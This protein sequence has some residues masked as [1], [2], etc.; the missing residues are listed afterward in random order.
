M[1]TTTM[2]AA[3]KKVS[4]LWVG[5][6]GRR[7]SF[8]RI[9]EEVLGRLPIRRIGILAPPRDRITDPKP[10]PTKM[11]WHV[12]DP[13]SH[14]QWE[15]FRR[16]CGG[17]EITANMKYVVLQIA[18]IVATH[19]FDYVL[20]A[21]GICEANWFAGYQTAWATAKTVVWVPLDYLPSPEVVAPLAGTLF[22]TMSEE[23]LGWLPKGAMALGHGSS[24]VGS[25]FVGSQGREG[26]LG[27]LR[28]MGICVGSE[29]VV[30]L[31]ANNYV[32]RKQF[33]ITLEAMRRVPGYRLWIHSNLHE[34]GA[35]LE[36]YEDLGDR[37]ILTMNDKPSEFL[38]LP[39]TVC[40]VGLQT[41]S[42]EGWSLTNCEHAHMGGIQVVPDFLATGQHFR[43]LG[44]TY[45][46]G[47]RTETNEMGHKVVV[48]DI[49]VDDVVAALREALGAVGTEGHREYTKAARKYLDGH[50]WGNVTKRLMEII[51]EK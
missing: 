30:V 36:E 24:F 50:S 1:A 27:V 33:R 8:S 31:N 12:G 32:P 13:M 25:H 29:E 7:N 28:G 46:V 43:K 41:S 9:S 34:L 2:A 19:K 10:Y 3:T 20:L 5:D 39:Y 22:L 40:Q 15:T 48:A 47:R 49:R 6:W 18:D 37:L 14:T 38:R 4:L 35:L 51:T 44:F 23:V 11:V 42:G 21:M 17:S 16:D 26:A 45:P